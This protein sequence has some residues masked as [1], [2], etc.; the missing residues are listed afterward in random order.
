MKP[1]LSQSDEIETGNPVLQRGR[2]VTQIEQLTV[3]AAKEAKLI[4]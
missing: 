2:A 4:T 1:V 3:S